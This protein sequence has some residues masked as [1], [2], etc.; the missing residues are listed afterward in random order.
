VSGRLP[1]LTGLGMSGMTPQ[2]AGLSMGQ[3]QSGGTTNPCAAAQLGQAAG[4]VAGQEPEV[5]AAAPAGPSVGG[6]GC[7][8]DLNKVPV[9]SG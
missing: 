4:G 8:E 6:A 2:T 9:P 7:G 5:P 3:A 1:G